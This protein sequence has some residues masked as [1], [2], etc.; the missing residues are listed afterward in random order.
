MN[1]SMTTVTSPQK[2]SQ[3][4]YGTSTDVGRG[5]ALGCDVCSDQGGLDVIPPQWFNAIRMM[6]AFACL[7]LMYRKQFRQLTRQAWIFGAAA[8][9]SLALGYVFQTQGLVYTTATNSAFITALVVVIVPILATIPG[10]VLRG[11]MRRNGRRGPA[12]WWRCWGSPC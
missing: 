5:H 4:C 7:A 11:T 6:I 1:S 12:L 10:F 9:A 8:G 3:Q 2:I